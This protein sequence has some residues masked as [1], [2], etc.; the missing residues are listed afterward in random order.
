MLKVIFLAI[1]LFSLVLFYY[2]TGKQNKILIISILWLI[3]IG[4]VAYVGYFENTSITPPRFLFVPIA[5]IS[6]AIYFYKIINKNKISTT[7]LVAIH[8]LRLPI[9]LVLY[10][11]FLQKQVPVLMTFKGWN[12]DILIGV[13]AIF[14]LVYLL[15]TKKKLHKYFLWLWN[16]VG[17]IFLAII[18]ILATLSSPTPIQQFAFEQPNVAVLQFPFIYLPALVVPLVFLSHILAIKQAD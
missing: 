13:S 8:I 2:G 12:F 18:V 14:I 1:T 15:L 16:S 9:E 5:A 17:L 6:L 4:R 3:I 11:L 7:F 10:K